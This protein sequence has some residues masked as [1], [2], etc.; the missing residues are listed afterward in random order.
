MLHVVHIGP[1]PIANP[2]LNLFR[3]VMRP[4]FTIFINRVLIKSPQSSLVS[5]LLEMLCMVIG[6]IKVLLGKL[7]PNQPIDRSPS[8]DRRPQPQTPIR[9]WQ[10]NIHP[11]NS[12]FETPN[13]TFAQKKLYSY[14]GLKFTFV[15]LQLKTKH[16]H[17]EK[18]NS[19]IFTQV[20][21]HFETPTCH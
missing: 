7:M 9:F 2:R 13:S 21:S 14:F 11:T 15:I 20:I 16:A 8:W 19:Q 17:M 4:S 6:P 5:D 18:G 1:N 12:T 3:L 10:A